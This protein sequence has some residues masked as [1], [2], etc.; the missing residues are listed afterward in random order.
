M[1][2]FLANLIMN[3]VSKPGRRL[4]RVGI[5]VTIAWILFANSS[6]SAGSTVFNLIILWTLYKI[7]LK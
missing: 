2:D 1:K 4:I 6:M 3:L 5:F 7:L